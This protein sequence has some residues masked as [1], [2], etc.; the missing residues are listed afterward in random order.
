MADKTNNEHTETTFQGH[1][2]IALIIIIIIIVTV[3][4]MMMMMMT[5][6]PNGL[7]LSDNS[8]YRNKTMLVI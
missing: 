1:T 3:M 5:N 6:L 7:G 4:M 8:T 2:K